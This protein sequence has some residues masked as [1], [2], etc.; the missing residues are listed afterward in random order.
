MPDQLASLKAIAQLLRAADRELRESLDE[1]DADCAARVKKV[2][3]LP[4]K[5]EA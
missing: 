4:E 1:Y 2:E 5:G 3:A